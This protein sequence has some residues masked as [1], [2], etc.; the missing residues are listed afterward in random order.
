[1]ALREFQARAELQPALLFKRPALPV[2]VFVRIA[3]LLERE[4][5][6]AAQERSSRTNLAT[7]EGLTKMI[8]R[9]QQEVHVRA[10][11]G[12]E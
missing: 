7:L 6:F 1:M 2:P 12:V 3:Q 4:R 10:E 8:A 9:H 11:S 5:G